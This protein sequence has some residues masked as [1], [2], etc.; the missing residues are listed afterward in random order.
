[1]YT[2]ETLV[3]ILRGDHELGLVGDS[4]FSLPIGMGFKQNNDPLREKFNEFLRGIKQ[5]GIYGGMVDRW[6]KK[7]ET[8]M[9]M[10]ANAK[11]NGVLVVGN[12][13]DKG[14]PFTIVMDNKLIGFDI[15]LTERFGAA[16]GKE[17]KF[18]DMEFG[19]LIAAASTGKVD[20]I[21]STLVM[22]EER[23]KQIAFSDSYYEIGAGVFALK[24]NIAAGGAAATAGTESPNF[25]QKVAASFYS[26][27]ILEKPVSSHP[28][29]SEDHCRDLHIR[30]GIRHAPG[31]RWSASCGCRSRHC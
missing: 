2:L 26:N 12:V 11:S 14:L 9:P 16:L 30:H 15:E 4:L 13:G 24:K 6:M 3:E 23:K 27:I 5:N 10:I 1:M 28:G 31:G 18:A 19:S 25:F 21:A 20:M 7:G 22:T 29:R 8:T 17:V